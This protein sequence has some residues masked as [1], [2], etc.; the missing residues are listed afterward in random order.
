M[1]NSVSIADKKQF[2]RWFVRNYVLQSNEATWLLTYLCSDDEVLRRVHFVEEANFSLRT[3]IISSN[4]VKMKPFVFY[5]KKKILYNVEETFMELYK[6]LNEDIYIVLYFKDRHNSPEYAYI[7]EKT[8]KPKINNS[9]SIQADM[10]IEQ[11]T[12]NFKIYDLYRKIDLALDGQ[13][14]EE[15][16]QLSELLFELLNKNESERIPIKN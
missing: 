7:V 6:N 12:V 13:N 14:K 2:L 15:F 11:A 16:F 5:N 3:I 9:I 4:C 10:I 1:S 8:S